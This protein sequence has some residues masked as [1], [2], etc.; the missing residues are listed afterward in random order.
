MAY[1]DFDGVQS[2]VLSLIVAIVIILIDFT[3]EVHKK[4]GFKKELV[5]CSLFWTNLI[6]WSGVSIVDFE[7]V[8]AAWNAR[9]RGSYSKKMKL[10]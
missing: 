4:K 1:I 9:G 5:L 3:I 10:R 2:T 8:N 7:Q 6:H